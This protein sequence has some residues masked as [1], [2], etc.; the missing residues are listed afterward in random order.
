[1]IIL[2]SI[3]NKLIIVIYDFRKTISS[4]PGLYTQLFEESNIDIRR[5]QYRSVIEYEKL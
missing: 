5:H 2:T 4:T 3:G 1:M